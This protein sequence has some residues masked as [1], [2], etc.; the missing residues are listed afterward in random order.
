M[1]SRDRNTRCLVERTQMNFLRLSEA[2]SAQTGRG[3][4]SDLS[5]FGVT[6][7]R[8]P[9]RV[10]GEPFS[11]SFFHTL[12][13]HRIEPKPKVASGFG[14]SWR[15]LGRFGGGLSLSQGIEQPP[16][17]ATRKFRARVLPVELSDIGI[18][19]RGDIQRQHIR[20]TGP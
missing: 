10:K 4:C 18:T 3:W 2:A 13:N 5:C 8:S 12:T 9:Q 15:A 7:I 16:T 20:D 19:T 1:P 11:G 17:V 6:G 14:L